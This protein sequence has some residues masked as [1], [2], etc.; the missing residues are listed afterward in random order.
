M[1]QIGGILDGVVVT[2]IHNVLFHH[3]PRTGGRES[4][5]HRVSAVWHIWSV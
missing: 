5:T 4:R 1:Q 2:P 3:T